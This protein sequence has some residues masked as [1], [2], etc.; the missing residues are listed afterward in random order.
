MTLNFLIIFTSSPPSSV[1]KS[2][3]FSG[4]PS[5]HSFVHSFIRTD[6]I[7]TMNALNSFVRTLT[8]YSLTLPMTW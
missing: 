7:T 1:G 3:R 6:I 5:G 2:I 4:C 8:E